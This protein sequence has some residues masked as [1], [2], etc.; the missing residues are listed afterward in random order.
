MRRPIAAV[1]LCLACV[2]AAG[3][4]EERP[5]PFASPRARKGGTLRFNAG[6][7]PRSFNAYIDGTTY[8]SMFFSLMYDSLVGFD[9]ATLAF[10]P[11]LA[12]SWSV[13]SDGREF[14]FELDPRAVWSDGRPVTA[15][16]V[17]ATFDAVMDPASETGSWKLQLGAFESPSSADGRT[18]VFRKKGSSPKDWRD[19][20]SLAGFW[21]L[22]AR[23]LEGASFN[24]L[25]FV[26]APVCGPYAIA[27]AVEQV[28]TEFRREKGWWRAEMPFN[29]GKY[30][31]DRILARYYADSGNAFDALKKRQIDVFPVY[32]ARMLHE[33]V[34]DEKF[35]RNWLLARR[36]R[37]HRPVG[38]Q[39]FA[40]NMR[41]FPFDDRRVRIAM[42]KLVDRETMNRTMMN[43]EYFMQS[44]FYQDL[45]SA[46]TPCANPLWLYDPEGAAALLAE[47]GWRRDPA[48]GRLMRDGRPF[49]FTFLTR[50]ASSDKFL[51][52]FAAALRAQGIEMS[53][54]RKDFAEWMRDMDAFNFDMTWQAW[55]AGKFKRPEAA[56]LSVEADRPQGGNTV[57]F[58]SEAVDR[59]IAAER[60]METMAEREAAY[61]EIDRLVAEEAPVAFLWNSDQTRL[62]YWNKFGMPDT[63]LSR[64]ED[65]SD[66]L[67]YWWYDTDRA[68]ELKDAVARGGFLP[69]VP[70]L[71]D[72]DAVRGKETE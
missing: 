56:W 53:I 33:G 39:G 49:A 72:F 47:A 6:P 60:T 29:R 23:L 40:M 17:K 36:V 11:A 27:R 8:G 61:R 63:V 30:N 65:E 45:Y 22:P 19:F 24:A 38:Y 1:F 16:D 26:G 7:A 18:V 64:Y 46:Q 71:V 35:K 41:R 52:L 12:R 48:T 69:S 55:G 42:A 2:C 32:V 20:L 15:A 25:D 21:I 37:N 44:S 28:E 5:D 57:G 10:V 58:R 59:L 54:V 70:M 66:V 31:F 51:V 62:M 9:P 34:R 4:P 50:D 67:V 3:V 68:A 13:S 43:G 14:R